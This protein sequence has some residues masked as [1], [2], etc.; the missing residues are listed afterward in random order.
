MA[1]IYRVCFMNR[2]KIYELYAESVHQGEL[3][4]FVV[5][6]GLLFDRH[7]TV[8][9][10]PGEEKLKAEFDGVRR[11]LLPMHSVI[12]VDEVEKKGTCKI[13]DLEAKDNVT[14]FP[15]G[16]YPPGQRREGPRALK[17]VMAPGRRGGENRGD[18][19]S[20]PGPL[21]R[22]AALGLRRPR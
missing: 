13:V 22:L 18:E 17:S 14:P 20:P 8:V 7:Q 16:F 6:E 9:I 11:T 15:A 1:T 12:R 21:A 4:G 5:V 2:G 3:Y 19:T 10:D